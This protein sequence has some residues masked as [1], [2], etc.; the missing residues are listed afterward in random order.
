MKKTVI[1]LFIIL[2]LAAICFIPVTRKKTSVIKAP[3]FNVYEQLSKAAN[4]ERWRTDL[5][6]K[7]AA[8]SARVLAKS[9]NNG[10]TMKFDSLQLRMKILDGYSFNINELKNGN[11]IEYNYV[12]TPD[13]LENQTTITVSERNT[14]ISYVIDLFSNRSWSETNIADLKNFMETPDLYYGYRIYKIHVTDTSIVVLRKKVRSADKFTDAA[15][16][17]NE[18]KQYIREKGLSETQPL[19]AQ[20]FDRS[21]DSTQVNIG[22]PVN[23]KASPKGQIVYMTMPSTGYFYAANFKGTFD[24]KQKAYRQVY[25]YFNDRH[26]QIPILPFDT[27]LDN[28]LPVSDTSMIDIRINF[29]TF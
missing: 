17:L 6:G 27:Y 12:V 20:F 15:K 9:E 25:Q 13:G 18:L 28:K 11:Q 21:N 23:K 22:I 24:M 3:F 10:F 19:M 2:V 1:A 14:L 7:M 26:M 8:D 5:R 4:W 16:M 29:P